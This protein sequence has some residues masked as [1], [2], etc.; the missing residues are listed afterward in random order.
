MNM[1]VEAKVIDPQHL[2]LKRPTRIPPGSTVLVE[3]S[4]PNHPVAEGKNDPYPLRGKTIQYIDPFDS[5]A[6]DD[7]DLL[8]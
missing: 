3:I 6:E 7:W 8:K 1:T 2:K 4:T 5:V